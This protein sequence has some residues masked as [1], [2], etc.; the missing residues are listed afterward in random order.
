MPDF[1]GGLRHARNGSAVESA[2][3]A[4]AL[5]IDRTSSVLLVNGDCQRIH[6]KT[7]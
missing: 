6:L 2:T 4:T 7:A 3:C 1:D 5:G